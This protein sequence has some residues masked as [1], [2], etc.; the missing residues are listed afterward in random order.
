MRKYAER[1][2]KSF[3]SIERLKGLYADVG[4]LKTNII[5]YILSE[6]DTIRD[7]V[8]TMVR[9]VLDPRININT[10]PDI[11]CPKECPNIMSHDYDLFLFGA[12]CLI[13]EKG[14]DDVYF[15]E[16]GT[17]LRHLVIAATLC[18][19]DYNTIDHNIEVTKALEIARKDHNHELIDREAV[20]FYM[21]IIGDVPG[22]E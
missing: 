14:D 1:R 9:R 6:R 16:I 5:R 13:K 12:R 7:M 11:A 3:K 22:I 10:E 19:T 18:G 4:K 2:R 8:I 20:E 17:L 21:S 15:L